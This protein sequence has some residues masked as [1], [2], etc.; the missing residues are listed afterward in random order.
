MKKAILFF[1][2][3]SLILITLALYAL[4]KLYEQNV[5][6]AECKKIDNVIIVHSEIDSRTSKTSRYQTTRHEYYPQIEFEY[7]INSKLYRSRRFFADGLR[8]VFDDEIKAQEFLSKYPVGTK[9]V[10][11]Y[12]PN[13]PAKAFLNNHP[14]FSYCTYTLI[15][16]TGAYFIIWFCFFIEQEIGRKVSWLRRVVLIGWWFLMGI[17]CFGYYMKYSENIKTWVICIASL[18]AAFGMLWIYF[19]SMPIMLPV[20]KEIEDV[21]SQY[22]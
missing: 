9:T 8:M 16:S 10:A 7:K 20:T 19:L 22:K 11:Y 2:C 14:S 6:L 18:Y 15:F 4:F 5:N 12:H 1:Y 3:I 13:F 21:Y 17:L